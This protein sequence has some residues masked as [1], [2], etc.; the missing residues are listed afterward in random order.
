MPRPPRTDYPGARHHVMSRGARKAPIFRND[1]H[2]ELFLAL[3]SELP[4]RFGIAVHGYALMPNHFHLMIESRRGELSRAMAYLLSNYTVSVNKLHDWDGPLFRG[5]FHNR[6]VY[7]DEH[8]M[9][10]LAYLHLN[11]VRARLV[12]KPEQARWTS[13]PCYAGKNPPPPWLETGQLTEM[14]DAVGG[15]AR[16]LADVRANRGEPPD[17]FEVVAFQAGRSMSDETV[18]PALKPRRAHVI[19]PLALLTA[20]CRRAEVSRASLKETQY[21]RTGNPARL[22]A[23]FLLVQRAGLINR[24]V[25]HLLA[26]NEVDVSKAIAKVRSERGTN[27]LIDRLVSAILIETIR[28]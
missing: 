10:L 2:C 4:A 7:R 19:S 25:G 5:R 16:Y 17:G 13:H 18:K 24:E 1:A 3:V 22:A 9:H 27:S 20:V 21:G 11:P 8:W 26:M 28:E 12:M 6:L 15:Y 23:A 14:F